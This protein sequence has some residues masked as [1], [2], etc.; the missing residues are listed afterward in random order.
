[1]LLVQDDKPPN[2]ERVLCEA[3]ALLWAEEEC[4]RR[5]EAACSEPSNNPVRAPAD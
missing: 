3:E 1:M 4:E 2:S 5:A